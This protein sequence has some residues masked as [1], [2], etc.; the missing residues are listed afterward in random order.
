MII[1]AR[2]VSVGL[3][4]SLSG[5]M[6]ISERP[7]LEAELMAIVE[8]N[9]SGGVL[10]CRI[11]PVVADGASVAMTFAQKAQEMLS[12]RIK[13][14][15]GCLNSA[16]R[17]AVKPL[18]EASAG[19][20]WYPARHEGLEESKHIV[21]TGSCLNQQITPAVDWILGHVGSRLFLLGADYVFPRTAN[22]L[23]RSLVES[24]G[25]GGSVVGEYY[26]SLG[27]GDFSE[28]IDEITHQ[29]P[30][31]VFSAL[32]GE[33][34]LAF[35]RQF[36]LAG[37]DARKIPIL[38]V[39]VS[40]TELQPIAD[41]AAG[42]L[43][44]WNYFQ[45]LNNPENLRFISAFKERYGAGRVCSAPMITAYGQIYLWKQAVEAAGSFEPEDIRKHLAGCEY[46]G[47]AGRITI[48]ANHHTTMCAYIGR[49]KPDGQFEICGGSAEP[50]APL[51]WL[52]V[53]ELE[54]PSQAL[55][56]ESMAAYA[57]AVNYGKLLEREIKERRQS[58]DALHESERRL[59]DI[60]E[61]LPDATLVIDCEGKVMA[62]N[63]AIERMT[64][65]LKED[66]VGR[67]DYAYGVPFYGTPRPILI[68]LVF[69]TDEEIK[70]K[71]DFVEKKGD[72][73]YAE[74]FAP[75]TYQGKGAFL[76]GQASP[77]T[78]AKGNLVGAI[79]SIR[80]ISEYR[81]AQQNLTQTRDYLE[82]VLE[83]SPDAIT[84]VDEHGRFIKWNRMASEIMGYT[85][86]EIQGSSA[87]EIYADED[88]LKEML[89]ALRSDGAVK[90]R[91]MRLRR[92]DG[93]IVPVELSLSLL[94]G[95]GGKA[96]GS[97]CVAR[98][99][100]VQKKLLKALGETNEQLL[101][102]I[103][104]R[105]KVENAL[106]ES[107]N[108]YRTIFEN[109]GTATV[110]VEEDMTIS[111]A[112]AQCEKISSYSKAEI[113]GSM[114][115]TDWVQEDDLK[116]MRAY[117]A[118]RR[119]DPK[120]A[121][122]QFEV[123]FVDRQGGIKNVLLT[124]RMIPGTTKSVVSL[125]DVTERGRAEE[126]LRESERRLADILEFL[127]DATLVI[128]HEG[129]VIAWNRAIERMTGVRKEDIIG[130]GDFAYG[131]PFY[132]ENRPILIDLVSLS[133]KEIAEKY[134]SL[135]KRGDT[136]YGEAFTPMINGGR[137]AILVGH[138]SPLFD[139]RGNVVGAI[140]SIRDIT[141]YRV[142]EQNLIKTK[143][144]LENVLENSPD[145]IGIVDEYGRFITWNRVASEIFGFTFEEIQGR[146]AFDIYADADEL[147]EMLTQLRSVGSVKSLEMKMK[148]KD[149]GIV[150]VE[151]SL[152]LLR[153]DDGK[154]LGSVCVARDLSDQ[155]KL[156]NAVR[157]TNEQL[158]QE[159]TERKK[160]EEALHEAKEEAERA[161]R[162]K[163]EFLANMSHEIRTPM[164]AIVG[165]SYLALKTNMSPKQRD[166]L[167]KIQISAH[168]LLGLLNDILDLSK[169]EAG[170][171]EIET[172][173][174]HLDHVL[175]N[176][177]NLVALK[178]EEKG[179]EIFF[180]TDPEMPRAFMGDP[181]RLG[182]V[183]INLV[184]NA[185][186]FTEKGEIIVSIELISRQADRGRLRFAVCDT[187]IG[188]TEE[189]QARLFQ[190][191]TQ[192]D[193]STTRKYGGTGLGLAISK[194]LVE[195]M[196][197]EI[198]VES[199]PGVGSTFAFTIELGLQPEALTLPRALPGNL[200]GLKVLVA[201]D[202][203]LDREVLKARLTAMSF[204]V[205]TVDS[206]REVL[207]ELIDR[208][209][210]YD[211]VLLDWRMPDMDGVETARQIKTQLRPEQT[212]RIFLITA[213]ARE[214]V[215]RQAEELG[216]D[217]FLIKPVTDS[218]LLDTFLQA[219]GPERERLPGAAPPPPVEARATSTLAGSRVLLVEDN[220]INRQVAREILEGF[221]LIVEV[222]GD[223]KR[224]TEMVAA[225]GDRFDAVLMDLQMPKMD[226]YTATRVIRTEGNNQTLPIIAMT[227]HALVSERKRCVE[228]GM[229]DY[230][231]KPV[232][233]DQLLATLAR[234][235]KPRLR[236]H[237]GAPEMAT[238]KVNAPA[239]TIS[240]ELA[241]S[242]PGID[243]QDALTRL[244]G[245]GKLFVQ[246]LRDF[247]QDYHDVVG[248]IREALAH[249]DLA[250][251]T[252]IV[253]TLKGVAGN[254]SVTSVAAAARI[255]EAAMEQG[256]GGDIAA[257]LEGLDAALK[258]VIQAVAQ[259]PQEDAG[260]VT[261]AASV[262][263]PK[264]QGHADAAALTPLLVELDSLLKKNNYT[265]R[266]H[267]GQL[268]EELTGG[269]VQA[270]LEQ[271]E[272]D[273]GRLN[274]KEAR[275][276]LFT[277][278][279]MLGVTLP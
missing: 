275:K 117:H 245:N 254:L 73:L 267:F 75:L 93:G 217:G 140:E 61:F 34:N 250:S 260:G 268:K 18:V 67:G 270:S 139:A 53:E 264:L 147:E 78:D 123:S 145:A 68:D 24:H 135:E 37:I 69:K 102:E 214:E 157:E 17:K 124:V 219:F 62:W 247:G 241:E 257:G 196:G 77:L 87:F 84:M 136:L 203:S 242:L 131:A 14:L 98:D 271:L 76:W 182:Q 161:T 30:A 79:E 246:L 65:V 107:E 105:K 169:I 5:A 74:T 4:H 240:L 7:V 193:G 173:Q 6:A 80:D 90:G 261:P 134:H 272:S 118:L 49:L 16:S 114:R 177:A 9:Q 38:S 128:D 279:Q 256:G 235:I 183:L 32:N 239:A 28:V 255:L 187:G 108:A 212:P 82:N 45:S 179:L 215:I 137:G 27:E 204:E 47:P 181:L 146:S 101:Q 188:M 1:Q 12:A 154:T 266:K 86:E 143:D 96:L 48:Q 248:Q 259:L 43:A 172:T 94:R 167:N 60:L 109:T 40:E 197:G 237:C 213:Y 230:V 115:W 166:Y 189:E 141:E 58:E 132:G 122:T 226:G 104:E 162:A 91:E 35:C 178:V 253:H 103:A 144:Y 227:A 185:V 138:A 156:L 39:S 263:P 149:G 100:S 165:L 41:I 52:G 208:E 228:T 277:I 46:T 152:S 265:A 15:F 205:T 44:C 111:L 221:G 180:R 249:D 56:K 201:D 13:V 81:V 186:K 155:K 72:N 200:R 23:V 88:E 150:P 206:G 110:I 218:V 97:V 229:N 22:K 148:R 121:P 11:D 21:Y 127:P 273:L 222:A 106:R 63:R 95:D 225:G 194:K 224:A 164:N 234:W 278:A 29:Q 174:F 274:F 269:A 113:E 209:R 168:S 8:I 159:I 20:L 50:I 83:N 262:A 36:H 276:H 126:A 231:S 170:R 258:P 199:A 251:A 216:L 176:V 85:F 210:S 211:L 158:L 57:E 236:E 54:F 198:S 238:L 142:T 3:I 71:Y 252:H 244:M 116:K 220:E 70:E 19:L 26:V 243:V 233:P 133:D 207:E 66:I 42:H 120:S 33:S 59:A 151:L 119:L 171:L 190:A 130:K 192:A 175:N 31:L 55:V 10:G 51:P 195:F 184:G 64:G 25:N 92:K 232:D 160:V 112:N 191:F 89:T 2:A 202:R 153:G 125:L 129:K 223:G 163:S 99:L